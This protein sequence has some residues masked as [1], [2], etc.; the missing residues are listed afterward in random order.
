MSRLTIA[1]LF[2]LSQIGVDTVRVRFLA[3]TSRGKINP[4]GPGVESKDSKKNRQNFDVLEHK[5]TIKYVDY[6][7]IYFSYFL[8]MRNK[9]QL[10]YLSVNRW[11]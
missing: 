3:K 2:K 8:A 9:K 6:R 4:G 5:S 11:R 10:T 7:H 1:T